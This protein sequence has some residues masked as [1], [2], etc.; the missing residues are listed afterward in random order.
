MPS[1]PS[2]PPRRGE[3][4]TT[5]PTCGA[6]FVAKVWFVVV[7]EDDPGAAAAARKGTL[8][9]CTCPRGHEY[10][11][12]SPMIYV[13]RSKKKFVFV[14]PRGSS[15]EQGDQFFH[16]LL[17]A[18]RH[19][20]QE[21][22]S[23]L[24]GRRQNAFGF[25]DLNRVLDQAW[26]A[27]DTE[28]EAER[29]QLHD[30]RRELDRLPSEER[31]ER[32][33]SLYASGAQVPVNRTDASDEFFDYLEARLA[34]AITSKAT[35]E[36]KDLEAFV[37]LLMKFRS[38]VGSED[39]RVVNVSVPSP[40]LDFFEAPTMSGAKRIIELNPELLSETKLHQLKLWLQ[41][42]SSS[43]GSNPEWQRF[44]AKGALIERCSELGIPAAFAELEQSG[45]SI[46]DHA[47]GGRSDKER[48]RDLIRSFLR[49]EPIAV[50]DKSLT[51]ALL[52]DE[53]EEAMKQI[54]DEVQ[55]EKLRGFRD[56]IFPAYCSNAFSSYLFAGSVRELKVTLA[57]HPR[58]LS[59][60]AK[61]IVKKLFE[62][63]RAL[64][65][66]SR[67]EGWEMRLDNYEE[68]LDR[69]RTEGVDAALADVSF[70]LLWTSTA[71][72]PLAALSEKVFSGELTLEEASIQVERSE[73]SEGALVSIAEDIHN[74]N[75]A[76]PAAA[77]TRPKLALMGRLA[78]GALGETTT[79]EVRERVK[80]AAAAALA[81]VDE[82]EESIELY[83]SAIQLA[84]TRTEKASELRRAL[85]WIRLSSVYMRLGQFREAI[86]SCEEAA[87]IYRS[88]Q[89]REGLANCALGV[90]GAQYWLGDLMGA[91]KSNEEAL[92]LV[93]DTGNSDIEARILGNMGSLSMSLGETN[94]AIDL[95][96]ASIVAHRESGD[97]VAVAAALSNLGLLFRRQG[98][99][100]SAVSCYRDALDQLQE[101][102]SQEGMVGFLAN[103][104][105]AY[106]DLGDFDTSMKYC[107][108]AVAL[109][110]SLG[111]E[112]GLADSQFIGGGLWIREG[113][114]RA[115]AS[116]S[117]EATSALRRGSVLTAKARKLYMKLGMSVQQGEAAILE[118]KVDELL[119]DLHGARERLLEAFALVEQ[120]RESLGAAR[121][122][123][124][125][126]RKGSDLFTLG[127]S[128][129]VA[130]LDEEPDHACYAGEAF[131]FAEA[132]KSRVLVEL[133]GR[134]GKGL[135]PETAAD[136][137]A[138]SRVIVT[139][140]PSATSSSLR[141]VT[142][143]LYENEGQSR[144]SLGPLGLEEARRGLPS[145]TALI[146]FAF[147][148]QRRS[149][150]MFVV[151]ADK[152]LLI[153]PKKI[154]AQDLGR[155]LTDYYGQLSAMERE[156]TPLLRLGK[157]EG[158]NGTARQSILQKY[159]GIV[160]RYRVGFDRALDAMGGL[161]FS[162]DVLGAL[163]AETIHRLLFVPDGPSYDIPFAALRVPNGTGQGYLIEE[164][165]AWP[166]VE[167]V[168]APSMSALHRC[169]TEIEQRADSLSS[170]EPRALLVSDPNVDHPDLALP[171][172]S[173]FVDRLGARCFEAGNCRHLT[174]RDA[175]R[176]S[177]Q[178]AAPEANVIL[179]YGHGDYDQDD[180][181][182][183]ALHFHN[184]SRGQSSDPLTARELIN[185][186]RESRLD[187][188]SL[189]VMPACWSMRVDPNAHWQARE[190]VGL[191]SSLFQRGVVSMIG[192]L[193]RAT[194]G[195]TSALLE[196]FFEEYSKRTPASTAL[197]SAQASLRRT[198][199]FDSPYFWAPFYLMGDHKAWP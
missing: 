153:A 128:V 124:H 14:H 160:S 108:R 191:S 174:G 54:E 29:R 179:F 172:V 63:L 178:K 175:T 28:F 15:P 163:R 168:T 75:P 112:P 136:E 127:V 85:Y 184:A 143:G 171:G 20:P 23:S 196:R 186:P 56:S 66:L 68:I 33:F 12:E 34:D 116:A 111:D 130:L 120:Q 27:D 123:E 2:R 24:V 173:K 131:A 80:G 138:T 96:K 8:N 94:E 126:Q 26:S 50:G 147:V 192:S 193:W 149:M 189:F 183:S 32:M 73:L 152:G 169:R 194:V 13:N 146:E 89:N 90:A 125:L 25:D 144:H 41:R 180:P 40:F 97:R 81:A 135:T 65:G 156:L 101:A 198:P 82:L 48:A 122:K 115:S 31:F 113:V 6:Q 190:I 133:I 117:E 60:E 170:A 76:H 107:D 134:A 51:N 84:N 181:L 3:Q 151:T 188:C 42:L 142:E 158:E 148:P 62:Q 18:I 79:S 91:V 46:W 104:G 61:P 182:D 95:F 165:S 197:R 36:E 87:A 71:A 17:S 78:L 4:P 59:E 195:P 55:R 45:S 49:T 88:H 102:G 69:C 39:D 83:R 109:A 157:N 35:E 74:A 176:S 1:P 132:G 140:H 139:D 114:R 44:F 22:L 137:K 118:G 16:M 92:K 9:V 155:T 154:A 159:E 86:A 37:A 103:L 67:P 30:T 93:R 53:I 129:C 11:H 43:P 150:V 10:H 21:E 77:T 164:G 38:Q 110:D 121:H 162:P 98:D 64:E 99:A 7:V 167:I 187:N 5:C 166:G 72:D 119:G 185:W 100:K 141:E 105:N 161:V 199:G 52:L 145:H 58:L 177:F 57:E 19:L 106:D 47:P 70:G